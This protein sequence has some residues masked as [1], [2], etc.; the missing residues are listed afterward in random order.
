MHFT[1]RNWDLKAL[2]FALK[3]SAEAFVGSTPSYLPSGL[4]KLITQKGCSHWL[5]PLSKLTLS[6]YEVG[7]RLSPLMPTIL[8]QKD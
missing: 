6:T 3:D 2:I 4:L 1:P 8:R 7:I 5:H